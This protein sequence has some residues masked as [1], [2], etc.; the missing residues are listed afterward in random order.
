MSNHLMQERRNYIEKR[1]LAEGSIR[2]SELTRFFD[3]S[4]ETIR[5]DLLYL[6]EHGVAKKAYGGAVRVSSAIEPSFKEKVDHVSG[7]KI[8]YRRCRA[9]LYRERY[10]TDS[11]RRVDGV[12]AG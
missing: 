9:R 7:R 12:C 2:I 3:V 5:K 11:R 1:L 8:A 6:E 10:V 4:S